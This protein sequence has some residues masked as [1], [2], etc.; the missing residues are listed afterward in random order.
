[1]G[2][3]VLHSS[4][5]DEF[6]MTSHSPSQAISYHTIPYRPAYNFTLSFGRCGEFEKEGFGLKLKLTTPAPARRFN[7][8]PPKGEDTIGLA[9]LTYVE[10]HKAQPWLRVLWTGRIGQSTGCLLP[11]W[12]GPN[13][14]SLT[15]FVLFCFVSFRYVLW[16]WW[17]WKFVSSPTWIW[18]TVFCRSSDDVVWWLG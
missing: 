17:M 7:K 10:P 1:M 6:T 8:N 16:P 12:Q 11:E 18:H 15:L 14:H 2:W 3:R 5:M 9:H 13:A 4:T